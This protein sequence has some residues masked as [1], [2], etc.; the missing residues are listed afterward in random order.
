[1]KFFIFQ[2][3]LF[4]SMGLRS[5]DFI[6][7]TPTFIGKSRQEIGLLN[8][9]NGNVS[10]DPKVNPG[11]ENVNII[12]VA[13]K[14]ANDSVSYVYNF[15]NDTCFVFAGWATNKKTADRLRKEIAKKCAEKP[16][17]TGGMQKLA[18]KKYTWSLSGSKRTCVFLTRQSK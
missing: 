8:I 18:D 12:S 11:F 9:Q 7:K 17:K 16:G 13:F 2:I 14:D 4:L 1:M 3:I 6:E 15:K 5:Q 10:F